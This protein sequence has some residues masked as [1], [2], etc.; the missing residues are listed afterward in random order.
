LRAGE[1]LDVTLVDVF[2]R[3]YLVLYP[4]RSITGQQVA[5][6]LAT[7]VARRGAPETISV[8]N[9][10][11]FSSRAME[12]LS[13]A[14]GVESA[15]IA[16]GKP[17]EN[18]FVES[19]NGRLRDELLNV[20]IFLAPADLAHKLKHWRSD[21]NHCRPHSAL[22]DQTPEEFAQ[23]QARDGLVFR[24]GSRSN[25]SRVSPCRSGA[26]L[27]L[28]HDLSA[29]TLSAATSSPPNV[30]VIGQPSGG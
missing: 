28:D 7:V 14:A 21:Y 17:V 25:G 20:E 26:R 18:A 9:G 4:E 11:E 16:P 30:A 23:R 15:F 22:A 5:A 3:E 2:T 6:E 13:D 27:D 19:F 1:A 10:P 24:G 29:S 8:D 12:A